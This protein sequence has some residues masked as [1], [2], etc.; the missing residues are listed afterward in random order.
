MNDDVDAP[1]RLIAGRYA[2]EREIGRGATAVV[3]LARDTQTGERVALKLLRTELLGPGSAEHF[4]R[5]VRHHQ[6]LAHP[7]ILPLLDS[8][9]DDG[10]LYVVLP[11][12]D[13]G[14]LRDRLDRDRQLPFAE[15][16]AIARD[17]AD[18]LDAAHGSSV[19]HRDVKPE[20]ILFSDGRAR[21]GDFGIARG[22][23]HLS[24]IATSSGGVVRGT[25]MYMSPEQASGQ[26]EY[27]GRSDLYS[28]GCVLYEMVAGVP[29]FTGP[30]AQSIIAQR[31]THAPAPIMRYRE[32]TPASL[33]AVIERALRVS[34]ADRFQTAREFA[35]ALDAARTDLDDP[36]TRTVRETHAFRVQRRR[37]AGLGLVAA[38]V[39]LVAAVVV[40]A[41]RD[42]TGGEATGT[43]PDGDPR[44]I[45]VLYF[46]ALT[47]DVLPTHVADGITEDLID[48][49]GSVRA[50]HVT[51]PNGVRLFRDARP[52]VD[53]IARALRVGTIVS[54]SIARSGDRLRMVARLIDAQSGRQLD[55]REL[56][57]PWSELFGLQDRLTEQVQFWL[58]QRLG[59]QI[60]GRTD[61]ASTRSVPAWELVQLADEE[62]RRA[63]R[64]ATIR[65]DSMSATLFLRA[66]SLYV[67]AIQLDAD[68]TLPMVRRGNLALLALALRSPRPPDGVD[69]M[70]YAAMSREDRR[71]AW[72]RRAESIADEVLRRQPSDVNALIIRGQ[73]R[74]LLADPSLPTHAAQLAAAER[75]LRAALDARPDLAAPWAAVADLLVQRGAFGDAA[76]AAQ[77]AFDADAF[78]ELR[79]VVDAA[80]TASLYAERFDD[81]ARWCALGLRRYAGDPRFTECELRLLGAA[82]RTRAAADSGW[83][84]VA[85]IERADT[86]GLL[87]P[88]WGFRRLMVAAVLARGGRAD[89]ARRVLDTVLATQ[90][91]V[92]AR[93]S[94]VAV[95]QVLTLLGD[96]AAAAERLAALM[97][98][99]PAPRYPLPLLPWFR[100]LRGEPRF[101]A[102]LARPD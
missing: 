93:A 30:S 98:T 94:E 26:P 35:D 4:L 24:G 29:V 37:R 57:E 34:P 91:E 3:H 47:P 18:A 70:A 17:I 15:A 73:A 43:V 99:R 49:L 101:D 53:S 13:G 14:T 82:G 32:L 51:S 74:A 8:G 9:D 2:I 12:M 69:S 11:Y 71:Q 84:L 95:A 63:A 28:L 66:D 58:R 52:P 54:G 33:A 81:A 41:T 16:I 56:E 21:L 40:L 60:N 64:A 65:G 62:T 77:R 55:S 19:I 61:R 85:D 25:P 6:R 5:E 86:L 97:E 1:P 20:N 46:D 50:L 42:R 76:D 83:R 100:A 27:D 96:H 48:H 75:D 72:T 44:R 7:H 87:A 102:L 45:A 38:L 36:A 10:H 23:E 92:S 88:T 22:L 80:F 90:P 79:R 39:A 31:L 59:E 68:W 67:R 78:Y 89:S